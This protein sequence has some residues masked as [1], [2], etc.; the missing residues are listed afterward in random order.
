MLVA[1]DAVLVFGGLQFFKRVVLEFWGGVGGRLRTYISQ[2]GVCD[3]R[4]K[5]RQNETPTGQYITK[6]DKIFLESGEKIY[7]W[8]R[9]P[10]IRQQLA[11]A[12]GRSGHAGSRGSWG[13][14]L[15]LILLQGDDLPSMLLL[16][17]ARQ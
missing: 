10:K 3:S 17:E 5:N 11:K 14:W 16:G 13:Q 2:K 12:A 6:M 1:L 7:S 4:V 8:R 15:Y 9:G